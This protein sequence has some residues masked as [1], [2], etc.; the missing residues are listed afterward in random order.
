MEERKSPTYI[1]HIE[2][3]EIENLILDVLRWFDEKAESDLKY[4]NR[5]EEVAKAYTEMQDTIMKEEISDY[6][7]KYYYNK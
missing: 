7:P 6:E 4:R 2:N 1:T 5:L 3:A